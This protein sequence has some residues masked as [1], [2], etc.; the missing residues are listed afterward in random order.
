MLKKWK[1][2]CPQSEWDLE[3]PQVDGRPNY[4]K[5]TWRDFVLAV[6]KAN[7]Q[8]PDNQKTLPRLTIHCLRHTFASIHLM[9]G[10]PISEVSAMLGHANVNITLT[11]YSHFIFKM[12]TDSAARFAASI[13]NGQNLVTG[14]DVHHKATSSKN[15]TS[16]N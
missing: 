12:R 2:Q 14:R 1:L 9:N 3:F 8:I 13:F 5:T 4:R 10:T 15:I 16:R 7:E 6:K 11:I